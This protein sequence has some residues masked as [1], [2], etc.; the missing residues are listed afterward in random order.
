LALKRRVKGMVNAPLPCEVYSPDGIEFLIIKIVTAEADM[1]RTGWWALLLVLTASIP[2][3]AQNSEAL[4][5]I[6]AKIWE[7]Q[8]VQRNF[9]G[10]LPLQ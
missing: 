5:D 2:L 1:T 10:G 7:A 4:N 3:R 8:L 6:K 9:S